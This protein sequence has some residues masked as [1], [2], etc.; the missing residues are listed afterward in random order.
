MQMTPT[1]RAKFLT[2]TFSDK[3]GLGFSYIRISIGCSDFSLSEYT[4]CEQKELR[5]SLC[6]LKRK[7]M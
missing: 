4:C 7:N 1:D 5:I 2:E 6:K 3:D